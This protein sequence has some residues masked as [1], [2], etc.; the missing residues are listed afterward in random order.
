MASSPGY[1]ARFSAPRFSAHVGYLFTEL[2][3]PERIAAAGR[4]GFVAVEH[5]APMQIPATRMRELLADA[6]VAFAQMG[7]AP[8]DASRGEKG[9]AALP[10]ARGRFR[11]GALA[12]L[13]YAAEIGCHMVHP[14]AGVLP[15]GT[16]LEAL[17][18]AYLDNLHFVAEEAEKRGLTVLIEPIGPGT[19][20]GYAIARTGDALRAITELGRPNVGML[21]DVFHGY[22]EGLDP[23]AVIAAESRRIAHIHLAD[24]PGR[25]EPGTG[26]IDFRA[27]R[28]ARAAGYGGLLGCEY[29]P[30]AGTVDG[31]TW[32]SQWT[33][34]GESG[35]CF[36][37][38]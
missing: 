35:D 32:M 18:P 14:M 17:W 1:P 6:G 9:L 11:D 20:P 5:P 12:G 25:H 26:W 24:E 15:Q 31:L 37:D 3:L 34:D 19:L 16:T 23:A 10:D 2:S 29:V 4:A 13:D 7:L 36:G 21:F 8:G 38:T 28:Q 27:I 30:R 33:G 22:R